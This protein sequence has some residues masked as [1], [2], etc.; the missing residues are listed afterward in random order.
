MAATMGRT[1]FKDE[2]LA[3]LSTRAN[4]AQFVS[5][6][7]DTSQRHSV[8]NGLAVGHQF[9]SLELAVSA[10][11]ERSPEGLANVRSFLPDSPQGKDFIY[12]LKS[13]EDVCATVR[14][15][16]AAGLHTI[17]N[18]TVDV[19]D[20]GVSGVAHGDVM[21]FAPGDTPRCVEKPGVTRVGR[22]VG[23]RLLQLVYG[24]SAD[25]EYPLTQRVEFSVHPVRRGARRSHTIIWEIEDLPNLTPPSA[26]S[27][28]WPGWPTRF[29][30]AMGDKA[31]GL[32][33][34]HLAGLS[35]PR[36]VVVPRA[37]PSFSFGQPTGSNEPWV[38]TCPQEQVPG[39]YSTVRGWT[40]PFALLRREDPS[41]ESISSVLI[42]DGV[43][44]EFSGALLSD[45]SGRP[46]I[47]GVAGVGTQ[48][49]IGTAPP[50]ALPAAVIR[51]VTAVYDQALAHLGPVR[52]EW[53]ADSDKVWVVQLHR[54]ASVSLG[55][56]IVPGEAE[57][58]QPFD[59]RQGLE[60]LRALLPVVQERGHGILIRGDVGMTSHLC[61][62]I[63]KA[64]VPARV[65]RSPT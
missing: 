61:D 53:V 19:R 49:M 12:G 33:V 14:R 44:A 25:T 24:F 42:Q 7:P 35:V 29:S 6:A 48:F 28:G 10:L 3:A 57:F 32:V 62:L 20:G 50:A 17:A 45:G 18:E 64:Q 56:T 37:V 2:V 31:F 16:A 15:L 13:T 4:V 40:D 51:R 21:E 11:L 26:E 38:R 46:L 43:D 59:V 63:R 55:S 39:K 60:Q 36:T 30:R 34:A 1:H 47:E 8:L 54:E 9:K 65:D 41:G 22:A 23:G 27:S 52:M 58:F 5:F